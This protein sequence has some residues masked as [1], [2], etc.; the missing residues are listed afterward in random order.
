MNIGLKETFQK[1][2]INSGSWFQL[3]LFLP[4]ATFPFLNEKFIK[5]IF[6]NQVKLQLN[7]NN[8]KKMTEKIE[9][10]KQTQDL[11]HYKKPNQQP[12][13]IFEKTRKTSKQKQKQ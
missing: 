1:R 5:Q 4:L 8:T 10:K 7:V 11:I 3:L 13:Y 9:I 6:I 2:F 12:Y